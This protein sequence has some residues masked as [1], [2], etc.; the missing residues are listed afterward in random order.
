MNRLCS[1]TLS[2]HCRQRLLSGSS[3]IKNCDLKLPDHSEFKNCLSRAGALRQR[4]LLRGRSNYCPRHIPEMPRLLYPSEFKNR[5]C[6][7]GG[8]RRRHLLSGS[9]VKISWALRR[10][11][12]LSGSNNLYSVKISEAARPFAGGVCS[13]F[14]PI[15]PPPTF[16]KFA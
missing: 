3:V 10:G 1:A 8:L 6:V 7:A 2:S 14:P 5:L 13:V 11:R 12:L 15:F 16:N 9:S 4:H